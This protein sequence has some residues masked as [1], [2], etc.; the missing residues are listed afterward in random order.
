MNF[1]KSTSQP[2]KAQSKPV[3]QMVKP[4]NP[5]GMGKAGNNAIAILIARDIHNLESETTQQ[6]YKELVKTIYK[7]DRELEDELR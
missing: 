7:L 3:V 4:F 1:P 5:M 2:I 6:L